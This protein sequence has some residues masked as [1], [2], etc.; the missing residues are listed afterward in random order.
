MADAGPIAW[1]AQ[2]LFDQ[3]RRYLVGY[4][5]IHNWYAWTSA[6]GPLPTVAA[7]QKIAGASARQVGEVV[8]MLSARGF[9]TVTS[10]ASDRRTKLLAPAPA[11]VGEIGRSVRLF[12]GAVDEILQRRPAWA[13]ALADA[14]RLGIVLQR[15]A[16]YVRTNG[17]LIHPFPRVLQ[18]AGRDCGYPLLCAVV[19]AHYAETIPG[20]PRAA[21]VGARRLAA[22]FGVSAA[23]A[24][25][26]LADARRQGWF[27]TGPRGRLAIPAPDLLDEF[28]R[29][30][31]W[32]MAHFQELVDTVP[33]EPT[34]G[35]AVG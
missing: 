6:G 30:A 4:M 15:S 19:G 31:S 28:E 14:D 29:W 32:Q 27:T 22:R 5:L 26:L 12:V 3:Y 34:R 21:P 13:D 11:L 9:V 17:T 33:C 16:A 2:K 10:D 8:A 7:L 35:P 18:F 25:S 24:A 23:H 1:P 20:A